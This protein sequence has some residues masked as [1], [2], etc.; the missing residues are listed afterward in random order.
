MQKHIR[1]LRK[2]IYY[3]WWKLF[4]LF[5]I[6]KQ[7]FAICLVPSRSQTLV[8]LFISHLTSKQISFLKYENVSSFSNENIPFHLLQICEFIQ[9]CIQQ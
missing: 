4:P 3:S 6:F 5:M 8:D 1:Q 9:K 7:I 2:C